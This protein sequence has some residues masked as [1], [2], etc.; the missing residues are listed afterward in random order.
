MWRDSP[1]SHSYSDV[2]GC[3]ARDAEED[4]E[5]GCDARRGPRPSP[6]PGRRRNHRSRQNRSLR[7]PASHPATTPPIPNLP[8]H[9][10]FHHGAQLYFFRQPLYPAGSRAE[11]RRLDCSRPPPLA[12][13]GATLATQGRSGLCRRAGVSVSLLLPGPALCPRLSVEA[14]QSPPPRAP[15]EVYGSP[16]TG[17]QALTLPQLGI[18]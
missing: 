6:A 16:R 12:F 3:I 8:S 2:A 14:V 11:P 9:P 18:T 1:G 10:R 4:V 15:S 17:L 7:A 13:P 5:S